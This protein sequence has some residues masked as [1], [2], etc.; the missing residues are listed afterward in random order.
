MVSRVWT[1][2]HQVI[3]A[4][5][6]LKYDNTYLGESGR[7]YVGIQKSFYTNS[8]N[9]D[10]E[11]V[12]EPEYEGNLCSKVIDLPSTGRLLDSIVFQGP[13]SIST[14]RGFCGTDS[15][16]CSQKMCLDRH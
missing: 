12:M 4:D 2:Y 6:E 14:F 11:R 10:V 7:V 8:D 9:S 3:A 15:I 13:P 16:M 1:A 5:L